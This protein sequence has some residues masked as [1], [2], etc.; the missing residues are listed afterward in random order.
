MAFKYVKYI[1]LVKV[2]YITVCTCAIIFDDKAGETFYQPCF[3]LTSLWMSYSNSTFYFNHKEA[4]VDLIQCLM[5]S[6]A[7]YILLINTRQVK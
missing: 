3:V 4:N 5:L 6:N 1:V 2:G 7:V